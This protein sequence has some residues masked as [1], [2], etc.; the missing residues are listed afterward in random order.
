ML[1]Y[2]ILGGLGTALIFTP[3]VSAIGHWFMVKRANATGIAAAGGAVGGVI[4]PLMLNKLFVELGWGWALR[5]QGFIF[6]LLLAVANL[7]IRSRLPP[8]PGG[9]IM[10]HFRI[11]RFRAMALVTA[12]TYFMEW[13]LFVPI[14]YLTSYALS[15]GAVSHTLAYQLIAVF[16]AGS[17]FGRWL[18]GYF[19]DKW[20]RYNLMILTLTMCLISCL[21]FWLPAA[22]LS[23][24]SLAVAS[25]SNAVF[26]LLVTFCL[27]MG[28]ASGSNISLTPVCVSMLCDTEEYGRYYATTYSIVSLGTLTGTPIAGAIV[29][30]NGGAYWGE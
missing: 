11:L 25:N 5:I 1:S 14:A 16:N 3:A 15:T 12:G 26:G 9:S 7:L 22:V 18:P 30:A 4:F 6:I 21:G 8:K 27:F 29:S 28:F 24:P 13:G 10:P 17:A 19:A 2:G 20:G 23:D